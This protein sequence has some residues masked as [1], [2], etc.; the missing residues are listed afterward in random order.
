MSLYRWVC[1]FQGLK[2]SK[3]RLKWEIKLHF[4]FL[5][6]YLLSNRPVD[7]KKKYW[8]PATTVKIIFGAWVA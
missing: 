3:V 4:E 1:D 6:A 5:M 2:V 7:I 8:N